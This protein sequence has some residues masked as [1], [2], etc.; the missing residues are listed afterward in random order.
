MKILGVLFYMGH[1][2]G[3]EYKS[4]YHYKHNP[5]IKNPVP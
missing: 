3:L 4:N 2:T 1:N 5:C